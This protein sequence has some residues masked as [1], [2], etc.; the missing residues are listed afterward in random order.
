MISK[1]QRYCQCVGNVVYV[2]QNLYKNSA[3][4]QFL[5]CDIV[6]V[7]QHLANCTVRLNTMKTSQKENCTWCSLLQQLASIPTTQYSIHNLQPAIYNSKWLSCLNTIITFI[8]QKRQ[9]THK[10]NTRSRWRK[11]GC[12]KDQVLMNAARRC[13]MLYVYSPV[14]YCVKWRHGHHLE[15]V[16]SNQ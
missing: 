14:L 13:Q 4:S 2:Q 8:C 6:D 1:I 15:T 10:L 16:T 9:A 12:T 5:F 3:I 7:G 11:Y